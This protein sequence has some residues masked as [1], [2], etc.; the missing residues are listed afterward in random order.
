MTPLLR[1]CL[2]VTTVMLLGVAS[3]AAQAKPPAAKVDTTVI[4]RI[5][6]PELTFLPE[7]LALKQGLRVRVRLI[8]NGT[9]PHNLVLVKNDDDLDLLASAA[10][11][12][13]KTEYV[14]LRYEAKMIAH[15]P[16]LS[17]GKE[18]TIEFTVP[19]PGSYTYVCLYPGH[20]NIMLGTLRS[21]K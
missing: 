15:S 8:N 10:L 14:P 9:L 13:D 6:G 2:A 17:T 7:Q 11:S 18:A 21:L 5:E 16:L 3:A 19:A 12:A 1:S 20:A 4:I